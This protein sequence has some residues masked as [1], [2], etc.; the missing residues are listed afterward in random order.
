M[1]PP[2]F[3]SLYLELLRESKE[4][5]EETNEIWLSLQKRLLFEGISN[6]KTDL[7]SSRRHRAVS[8]CS[9]CNKSTKSQCSSKE[10]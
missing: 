8:R 3:F 6:A 10:R 5:G 7:I 2:L 4:H 1:L 9:P